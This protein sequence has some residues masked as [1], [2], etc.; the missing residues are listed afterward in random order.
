MH[1]FR[2][3]KVMGNGVLRRIKTA[4]DTG[5][6]ECET[7][8]VSAMSLVQMISAFGLLA[9]GGILGVLMCI[10]ENCSARNKKLQ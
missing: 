4:A 9:M 2:L 1:C 7:G 5:G 6:V 8:G 3:I 10:F